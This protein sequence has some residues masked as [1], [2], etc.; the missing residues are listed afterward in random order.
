M[1]MY[2]VLNPDGTLREL[3]EGEIKPGDNTGNRTKPYA[4]PVTDA[5]PEIAQGERWV[6]ERRIVTPSLV[7]LAADGVEIIPVPTDADIAGAHMADQPFARGL[8][9]V[10]ANRF[11]MTAKQLVDAVK[12]QAN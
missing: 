6:N 8:V 9:R 12:A 5:R 2:A 10:L 7:T 11:G 3:R 1:T 4:V